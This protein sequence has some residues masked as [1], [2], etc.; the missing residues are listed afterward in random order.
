MDIIDRYTY[1]INTI[2]LPGFWGPSFSRQPERKISTLGSNHH[3]HHAV[4]RLHESTMSLSKILGTD[5]HP[6]QGPRA[7][8]RLRHTRARMSIKNGS[9]IL[10]KSLS[11]VD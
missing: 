2:I 7:R 9:I 5:Q 10:W 3:M 8:T 4:K 11:M 6:E 1:E